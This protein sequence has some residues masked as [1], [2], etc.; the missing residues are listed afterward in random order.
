MNGI[1]M[2]ML[3][4]IQ[5]ILYVLKRKSIFKN[6][7]LVVHIAMSLP[8]RI[9]PRPRSL[10]SS[11]KPTSSRLVPF[12]LKTP[13]QLPKLRDSAR[14][15]NSL[16]S[17]FPHVKNEKPTKLDEP[18][19]KQLNNSLRN[20][21]SKTKNTQSL[22]A[23]V[24]PNKRNSIQTVSYT[25][26]L[27]TNWGSPDLIACSEI[28]PIDSD[29]HRIPVLRITAAPAKIEETDLEKLLSGVASQENS[30][31][32]WTAPW[33]QEIPIEITIEVSIDNPLEVVRFF[34]ADENY[35]NA[36]IRNAEIWSDDVLLWYG[37]VPND[38]PYIAH[39]HR[40][41]ENIRNQLKSFENDISV[42]SHQHTI[43]PRN[44]MNCYVDSFGIV[45]QIAT[46]SVTIEFINSYANSNSFG[47]S[48]IEIV[49]TKKVVLTSD[50]FAE[51]KIHHLLSA[52]N[53]ATLFRG[54]YLD[55]KIDD[56]FVFERINNENNPMIS[57]TFNEP[58]LVGQ[59]RIWNFFPFSVGVDD[60]GSLNAANK[61]KL[62]I[63]T[64]NILVKFDNDNLFYAGRISQ[65]DGTLKK[66]ELS[67]TL[68]F[69][70]EM[71]YKFEKST[72]YLKPMPLV[73]A[74]SLPIPS[75]S[76]F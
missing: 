29:N 39:I 5:L 53:P 20:K 73:Q 25:L 2:K 70:N 65:G 27:I 69:V 60:Y 14:D 37:E 71:D 50:Q 17:F 18:F 56:M 52:G 1:E 58:I 33:P 8:K 54:H 38:F 57:I 75:Y 23:P 12:G 19:A 47:L 15:M 32:I 63:C 62:G 26:K 68:I 7:N 6:T 30:S 43:L 35:K 40:P 55:P 22:R 48:G 21:L 44:P 45:P 67:M 72:K 9:V 28:I 61:A 46:K 10:S 51:V 11:M 42:T 64:K 66:L 49:D 59:L 76:R 16:N 13:P 34:N 41:S 74:N 31:D 36:G 3:V 4:L 24:Y